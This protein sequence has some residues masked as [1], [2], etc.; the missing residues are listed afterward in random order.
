MKQIK[1]KCR[2]CTDVILN[3]KSSAEGCNKTLDF[4]PGSNFLGMV[5]SQLYDSVSPREALDLFHNGVVRYGDAHLAVDGKRSVKVPAAMYHPKLKPASEELYI[6]YAYDREKDPAK[7][8]LKQCREGFYAFGADTGVTVEMK[9]SFAIKSAYDKILRKSKDEQMFGYES[10]SAGLDFYFTVETDKDEY[11]QR[12]I[13]ALV[14][15]RRLGRSRN[16]QFGLVEISQCDFSETPSNTEDRAQTTVYADGRLIFLDA[17]GEPTFRPTSEQ[18]GIEGGEIDWKNSQIR[19]FQYAPWNAKRQSYDVDRC[20]VEKGSVFVVAGGRV[21]NKTCEAVGKYVNEGFGKVIYNPDFLAVENG[22]NGQAKYRICTLEKPCDNI[23]ATCNDTPLLR[24]LESRQGEERARNDIYKK[25]NEFVERNRMLFL[26][27]SFA[28][29]WGTIRSIAT[30]RASAKEIKEELFDKTIKRDGMTKP[31]AY[32]THGVAE[33]KW[34][35]GQRLAIFRK[36]FDEIM[37]EYT[38][39]LVREALIN[40]SSQMAKLYRKERSNG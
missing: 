1:M 20:G 14:G 27:A 30:S 25:V 28:S 38:D 10:L 3:M 9:R 15:K 39:A 6:Y 26:D 21:S 17:C 16:A 11:E 19:T 8:Q 2:L 31:F 12:I 40:L 37:A 4:I 22:T 23:K 7:N 5:A 13:G 18:L 32:L 33:E 24:F 29:Q 34:A 35:K 36:F